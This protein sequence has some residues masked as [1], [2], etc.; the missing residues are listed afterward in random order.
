ML[1]ICELLI[2]FVT[3]RNGTIIIYSIILV[4]KII[5]KIPQIK[6]YRVHL[7][8]FIFDLT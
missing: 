1:S 8:T 7:S 2:K 6:V 5:K 4:C 3:D